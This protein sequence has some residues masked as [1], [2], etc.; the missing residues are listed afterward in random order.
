MKATKKIIFLIAL[1]LL[2]LPSVTYAVSW[3]PL[4]PCGLNAQPKDSNGVELSKVPTE[5]N[6]YAHDYTQPCNQCDLLKLFKNI[7][8]FV[9]VGLMPPAAAILFV[10]GGFLILMGGA[11]PGWIT[12]GRSIF[13]NTA[14]G[15]AI[16]LASWLITNT[17]IRSLA[18]D[19]IAPEWWKF[20]CRVTTNN[21]GEGGGG[22]GN[23]YSCTNNQCIQDVN[24]TYTEPT[25]NNS[26]GEIPP[27]PVQK[28]SCN[29]NN[30]CVS[31][32]NGGYE[33]SNCDSNCQAPIGGAL[34]I[35][36]VSLPD[37]TARQPYSYQLQATGGAQPYDF[38]VSGGLLPA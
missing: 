25:C 5:E 9:L 8:D 17:I 36:T 32:P 14:I 33:S 38:S 7:I 19:N 11:N 31:D 10:W 20:E 15:V 26:C 22:G 29:S 30:Q 4:V 35:S 12:Q 34:S 37:G 16:L 27:P 21:G 3:W 1:V 13:F 2:I 24:G 23:K 28:Y 6:P 18:E